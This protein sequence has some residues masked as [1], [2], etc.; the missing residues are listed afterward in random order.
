MSSNE[1][2]EAL[3]EKI[4]LAGISW[5]A[6]GIESGSRKVRKN[7]HKSFCPEKLMATVSLIKHYDINIIGNYIFGLPEDNCKTMQ[8]TLDLAIELNCEFA[9]F[10]TAM[11]YPGSILYDFAIKKNWTL[12]DKW[13]GFSQHSEDCLP[14]PTK[15]LSVGEVLQFRDQAFHKYFNNTRYL[16]MLQKKFGDETVNHIK[17]MTSYNLKRNNYC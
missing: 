8:E 14:L 12:P 11:A 9:N 13:S 15:Y 17:K 6:L 4:K 16:N 7:I 3:L 1:A 5:L 10:Y 2:K